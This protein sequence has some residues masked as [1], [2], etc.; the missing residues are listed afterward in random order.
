MTGES[1]PPAAMSVATD[2]TAG[3][4]KH[5]AVLVVMLLIGTAL[6]VG[7][8]RVPVSTIGMPGSPDA[9][10]FIR[11]NTASQAELELL[12]GV[13]PALAQRIARSRKDQG[14]F[15]T[16]ADLGRVR[17]MGKITLSRL[18]EYVLFE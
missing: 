6:A 16:L 4:A 1:V 10:M 15:L 11:I 8:R 18:S 13:G 12:P 3:P 17:G 9:R 5:A 7:W 2:W 14:S